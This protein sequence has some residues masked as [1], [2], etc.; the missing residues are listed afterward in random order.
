MAR[1]GHAQD[2]HRSLTFAPYEIDQTISSPILDDS[3]IEP[4]ERRV[5]QVI[6]EEERA[7]R[8]CL[9]PRHHSRQ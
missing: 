4:D 1:S 6:R 7:W 5:I 8:Q 9:R 3:L 2:I